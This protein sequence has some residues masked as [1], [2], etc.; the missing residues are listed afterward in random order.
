MVW[1]LQV[2]KA[3]FKK[4]LM[5]K[6]QIGKPEAEK[7]LN[8]FIDACEDGLFKDKKITLRGFGTLEVVASEERYGRNPQTGEVI[9]I[10]SSKKVHFSPADALKAA[11]NSPDKKTC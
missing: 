6:M 1:K 4:M 8:A 3:D 2:K 11:I 7:I 10:P 5:E 9:T